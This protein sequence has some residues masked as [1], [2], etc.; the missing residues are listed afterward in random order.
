MASK[1]DRKVGICLAILT[2]ASCLPLRAQGP[3]R[4][5]AIT[6][7]DLPASEAIDDARG[8][9]RE[10]EQRNSS[11]LAT[12]RKYH[13]QALG[14]VNEYK[15][16]VPGKRDRRSVILE[17]WLNAGMDLGNHTYSHVLMS[18]TTLS[19]L[20]TTQ[21]GVMWSRPRCIRAAARPNDTFDIW[22]STR[23]IQHLR[24]NGLSPLPTP[25]APAWIT[26]TSERLRNGK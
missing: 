6:I 1:N 16:Q 19:T 20:K 26:N 13:A 25:Q 15:V 9:I 24:A 8:D 7:D 10:I 5:M 21:C 14:L 11:I 17:Q 2:L 22:V 23:A 12:L 3:P 4:T 18:Q